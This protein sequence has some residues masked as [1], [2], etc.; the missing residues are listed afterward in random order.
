MTVV[1]NDTVAQNITVDTLP[2]HI[3]NT[4]SSG[5]TL[6]HLPGSSQLIRGRK[7]GTDGVINIV[8]YSP[9]QEEQCYA[10]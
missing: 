8:R 7:P 2:H 10:Q 9:K 1:T 3:E 5:R 4:G 6:G